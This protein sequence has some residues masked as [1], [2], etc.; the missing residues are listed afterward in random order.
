MVQRQLKAHGRYPYSA[1]TG[2]KDYDWPDGKRLAIYI[3][4]NIEHFEFGAGHGA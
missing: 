1:I 4:F 3:G 2:R